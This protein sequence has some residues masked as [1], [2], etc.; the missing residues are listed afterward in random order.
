MT[1]RGFRQCI[2]SSHFHF[3]SPLNS[4]LFLYSGRQ[5]SGT[6]YLLHEFHIYDLNALTFLTFN[7]HCNFPQRLLRFLR[8]CLWLLLVEKYKVSCRCCCFLFCHISDEHDSN[9]QVLC[10]VLLYFYFYFS[11]QAMLSLIPLP[12]HAVTVS[13]LNPFPSSCHFSTAIR[14]DRQRSSSADM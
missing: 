9:C 6:I 2:I 5:T 7:W 13:D 14:R 4:K 1:L 12:L 3:A 10:S 11:I 8:F